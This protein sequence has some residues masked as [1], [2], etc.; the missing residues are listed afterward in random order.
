MTYAAELLG[1]T[2][3]PEQPF[4]ATQLT[5]MARSFY[6]ENKRVRNERLRTTLGVAPKFPTYREGIGALA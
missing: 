3:P 2:P 1:I 5:P 4:E 6:G